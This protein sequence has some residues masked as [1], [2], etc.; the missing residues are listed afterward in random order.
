M[1]S[2]EVVLLDFCCG[3]LGEFNI[4]LFVSMQRRDKSLEVTS[5]GLVGA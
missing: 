3:L 4:G 5:S 1:R 2:R